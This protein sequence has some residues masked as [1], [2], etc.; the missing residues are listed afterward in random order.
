[1][2]PQIVHETEVHRQHVRLKIPIQVE[3]DGV[4]YQVDDWS[5]GGFGIESDMTSR[6]AGERF[7]AKL[8]F[9]FE[10]FEI[11]LRLDCQMVYLL[12]DASRFGCRF[13][14]LSR[15][16]IGLFRYLVDAYLSGEVVSAGDI[17]G[18]RGR[19]GSAQARLEQLA[20][21]PFAEE[22]GT[23]RRIRRIAGYALLGLLGV[24]LVA[25]VWY[26]VEERFLTVQ[27]SAAVVD[28]PVFRVRAPASGILQP[29]SI[30]EEVRAGQRLAT[31][32]DRDGLASDVVSP[33]ACRV[34]TWQVLP[35]QYAQEGEAVVT[36]VATDRP[37]LVRAEV[38]MDA[39]DRLQVGDRA[40]VH[41]PGR[42]GALSGQIERIDLRQ[43]FA[44]ELPATPR[45]TVRVMVRTDS[46]LEV[47]Q[48]G[49][50]AR[51]RFH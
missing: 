11:V 31:I 39:V 18:L 30:G 35:G 44:A 5:M 2:Q 49:T 33:C 38:P 29:A 36:L 21:N 6:Q 1:M 14:S 25:A 15:D 17:L 8:T 51:V 43:G 45:A 7:S 46:P 50:V 32:R 23:G 28:A 3:I 4:R 40:V 19:D 42:D 9:P 26:G 48:V 12:S 13:V 20:A 34:M 24:A 22:E 10:D 16:Q 41:L 47:E 27:A 37:V